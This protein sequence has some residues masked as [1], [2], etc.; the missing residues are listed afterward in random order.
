MQTPG[1]L[2]K[3][4]KMASSQMQATYKQASGSSVNQRGMMSGK[5]P[6]SE[7]LDKANMPF[8]G[9]SSMSDSMDS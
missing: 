6:Y 1:D 2:K 7:R 8:S 3:I 4:S 9:M 5:N